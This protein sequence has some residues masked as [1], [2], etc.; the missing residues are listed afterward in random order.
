MSR[1]PDP[2]VVIAGEPEADRLATLAHDV[3][4]PLPLPTA[5]VDAAYSHML[6]SVALTTAEL[7]GSPCSR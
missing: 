7:T 2:A 1:L 5:G 4:D 3:R 6:L